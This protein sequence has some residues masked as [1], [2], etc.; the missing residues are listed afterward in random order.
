VQTSKSCKTEKQKAK[1]Q[2]K[3]K[4]PKRQLTFVF[5]TDNNEFIS[6]ISSSLKRSNIDFIEQ[7]KDLGPDHLI[8]IPL[9]YS[10]RYRDQLL[11]NIEF[12]KKLSKEKKR[13]FVFP[14]PLDDD[15]KIRA[16]FVRAQIDRSP[17]LSKHNW[18]KI[19]HFSGKDIAKQ[20]STFVDEMKTMYGHS[21]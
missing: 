16:A 19:R 12:A 7:Y 18:M 20:I 5:L 11:K 2:F 1:A 10:I 21:E 13:F 17:I 6:K 3:Q 4:K 14:L 8:L 15:N 9:Q